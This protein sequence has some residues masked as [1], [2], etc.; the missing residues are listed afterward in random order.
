ME[1]LVRDGLLCV[2]IHP[3]GSMQPL[4]ELTFLHKN[5]A[6]PIS[7]YITIISLSGAASEHAGILVA[8]KRFR[9]ARFLIDSLYTNICPVN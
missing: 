4:V 5:P 1:A 3:V 8:V 2:C 7:L 6:V 9:G